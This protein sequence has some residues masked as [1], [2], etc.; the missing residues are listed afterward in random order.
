[1]QCVSTDGLLSDKNKPEVRAIDINIRKG[2]NRNDKIQSMQ[3]DLSTRLKRYVVI[4]IITLLYKNN[5]WQDSQLLRQ[6]VDRK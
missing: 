4:E 5:Y 6:M 2:V 1:M 3:I